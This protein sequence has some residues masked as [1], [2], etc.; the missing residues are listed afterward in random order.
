MTDKKKTKK[1][2]QNFSD[3]DWQKKE[4]IQRIKRLTRVRRRLWLQISPPTKGYRDLTRRLYLPRSPSVWTC[5]HLLR[6]P[7]LWWRRFLGFLVFVVFVLMMIYER[8]RNYS[9]LSSC[10]LNHHPKKEWMRSSSRKKRWKRR[11]R[12]VLPRRRWKMMPRA[13][14]SFVLVVL[15]RCFV[16]RFLR[17]STSAYFCFFKLCF[18]DDISTKSSLRLWFSL[19]ILRVLLFFRRTKKSASKKNK[20]ESKKSARERRTSLNC[21]TFTHSQIEMSQALSSSR[22]LTNASAVRC[23]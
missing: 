1:I 7:S 2:E 15:K 19:F 3:D 23:R 22:V 5:I 11:T 12:C 14:T 4:R 6:S 21:R 20:R 10:W 16:W 9:F 17:F 13:W 18:I 8:K